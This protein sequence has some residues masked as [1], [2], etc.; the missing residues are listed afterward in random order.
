MTGGIRYTYTG[1]WCS[2]GLA[3]SWNGRWRVS[4]EHGT[5]CWDGAGEPVAD[6]AQF[7][8]TDAAPGADPGG[9]DDAVCQV[10]RPLAE[11][12]RALRTGA[13]PWGEC[14]DNVLTLAMAEA[15]IRSS[16]DG[17]PVAVASLLDRAREAAACA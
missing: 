1:S 13:V 6:P 11:F 7:L 4:G 15:A 3:T 9:A 8:D 16:A 17:A 14:G 10:S 5:A 12:V 2:S